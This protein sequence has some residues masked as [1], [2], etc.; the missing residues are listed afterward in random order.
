MRKLYSSFDNLLSLLLNIFSKSHK[1]DLS[2]VHNLHEITEAV[3]ATIKYVNDYEE[4]NNKLR[5]KVKNLEFKIITEN[6]TKDLMLE[7]SSNYLK[8]LNLF[9]DNTK[10]G[11]KTEALPTVWSY[12]EGFNMLM[13][14][15]STVKKL[16]NE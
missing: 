7:M 1:I 6:H 2:H 4:K 3:N 14:K 12:K 13:K 8:L 11:F 16:T 15:S 10:E 9:P 5:D